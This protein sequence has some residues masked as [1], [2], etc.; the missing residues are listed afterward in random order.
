MAVW[1]RAGLWVCVTAWAVTISG[2]DPGGDLGSDP[3]SNSGSNSAGEQG[4]APADRD[5][6]QRGR[7][8]FVRL[9]AESGELRDERNY[10]GQARA[11]HNGIDRFDQ[12]KMPPMARRFVSLSFTNPELPGR[13]WGYQRDIRSLAAKPA[14][15]WPFTVRASRD[16]KYVTLTWQGDPRVLNSAW[17]IDMQSGAFVRIR[18]GGRYSFVAEGERAFAFALFQR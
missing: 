17:L 11:A 9:T 14:G 7:G 6:P 16:V 8:W 12:P 5:H 4:S 3:A 15:D 13:A 1:L 18:P 10:L 2:N